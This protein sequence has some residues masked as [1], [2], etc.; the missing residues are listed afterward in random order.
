M[1]RG[2]LQGRGTAQLTETGLCR[3]VELKMVQERVDAEKL[4]WEE[5]YKKKEVCCQRLNQ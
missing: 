2:S 4:M 1:V 5:N 3:Q